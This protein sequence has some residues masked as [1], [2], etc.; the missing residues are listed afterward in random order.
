MVGRICYGWLGALANM[1]RMLKRSSRA[2]TPAKS[3]TDE[4]SKPKLPAVLFDL[5]GTLV[6]SVYQHVE[7]W[8]EAL[9][10][11]HVH[12]PSFRIHR[13]VGMSGRFMLRNL[14]A[15]NGLKLSSRMIDTLEA[16]HKRNFAK[17]IASV[18]SLPGAN[19][20]LKYLT[21]HRVRWAIATSGEKE[22]VHRMIKQLYV[23]ASV[24]VVTGDDVERA[25]PHPDVFLFAAIR[26]GVALEDCI[27]IGDSI[28]D[29]LAARRAKALPVGLLTGGYSASELVEAGAIR[30]Y[31]DPAHL[32]ENIAEI[33]LEAD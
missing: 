5:D 4:R 2:G 16:G 23:P 27:V 21:K 19:N 32:L 10:N 9:R 3:S 30:T 7:A 15:E 24:P 28:W 31:R 1:V 14:F 22:S 18:Q 6:D 25:K 13:S 29:L 26:L 33:G 12:F 11:L 8:S 20:L 17:K